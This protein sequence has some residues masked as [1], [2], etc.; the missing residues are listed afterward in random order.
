MNKEDLKENQYLRRLKP[1]QRI[2]LG[3]ELHN[4]ARSRVAGEIKRRHPGLAK[5]E[6]LEKLNQ[7]FTQ[8]FSSGIETENWV[9][10]L[11]TKS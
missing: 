1:Y 6:L 9:D 5:E 11:K 3:F 8:C 2:Q 4:L 7:R 10:Y